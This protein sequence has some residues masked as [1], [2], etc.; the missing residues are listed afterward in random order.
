MAIGPYFRAGHH[1]QAGK[2]IDRSGDDFTL[3]WKVNQYGD[4]YFDAHGLVDML[5]S[6][7][8]YFRPDGTPRK[9]RHEDEYAYLDEGLPFTI[10][11]TGKVRFNKR[12]DVFSTRKH[13]RNEQGQLRYHAFRWAKH[14]EGHDYR[15]KYETTEPTYEIEE[16][17]WVDAHGPIPQVYEKASHRDEDWKWRVDPD[18]LYDPK[19]GGDG[20]HPKYYIKVKVTKKSTPIM[21]HD[22]DDVDTLKY[23][24]DNDINKKWWAKHI[25]I[26]IVY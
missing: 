14:P 12:A 19:T 1:W 8:K 9:A 24:T 20:L 18:Y 10:G 3:R 17:Q 26:E 6:Y 13:L 11:H 2:S 16:M 22:Y 15:E 21:G 23:T 5:P 7:I 4:Y 25:N